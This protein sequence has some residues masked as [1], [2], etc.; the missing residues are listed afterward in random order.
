MATS[1]GKSVWATGLRQHPSSRHVGSYV[2]RGSPLL[3]NPRV[4]RCI[5][6]HIL[7]SAIPK[8]L[9][10]GTLSENKE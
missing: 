10:I 7:T 4:P 3:V 1:A 5:Q 2:S 9:L 6:P 8:Q